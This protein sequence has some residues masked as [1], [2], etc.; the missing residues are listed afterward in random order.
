MVV[1][2]FLDCWC[3]GGVKEFLMAQEALKGIEDIAYY[4][5]VDISS[6]SSIVMP[7]YLDDK[8]YRPDCLPS[9][10]DELR[11]EIIKV[12]KAKCQRKNL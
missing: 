1:T 12:H 4:S 5:V 3:L 8:P 6:T 7:L 9:T 2:E 10:V 11:K